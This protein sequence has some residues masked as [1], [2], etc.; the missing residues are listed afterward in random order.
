MPTESKYITAVYKS[1][2]KG[3]HSRVSSIKRTTLTAGTESCYS[4]P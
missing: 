4:A 1:L 3:V 2:L